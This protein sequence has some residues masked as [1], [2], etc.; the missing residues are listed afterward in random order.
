MGVLFRKR[1]LG[2]QTASVVGG[3]STLGLARATPYHA[4]WCLEPICQAVTRGCCLC[5]SQS[6]RATQRACQGGAVAWE[7][8]LQPPQ[9]DLMKLS[10]GPT[11]WSAEAW[12]AFAKG[13]LGGAE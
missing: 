3:S 11:P 12:K 9:W 6:W 5:E 13:S 10:T 2:P 1:P 7:D 4:V 8:I